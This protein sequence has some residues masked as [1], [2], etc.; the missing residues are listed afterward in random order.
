MEA[1]VER[2][3]HGFENIDA[4]NADKLTLDNLRAEIQEDAAAPVDLPDK[5]VD[6]VE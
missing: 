3:S 4:Y 5:V 1:R 6:Q 2:E